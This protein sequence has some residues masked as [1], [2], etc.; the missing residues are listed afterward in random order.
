LKK[1][2]LHMLGLLCFGTMALGKSVTDPRSLEEAF[3]EQDT[4]FLDR[5]YRYYLRARVTDSGLVQVTLGQVQSLIESPAAI[6]TPWLA[7]TIEWMSGLNPPPEQWITQL[8]KLVVSPS[9]KGPALEAASAQLVRLSPATSLE[10]LSERLF[11]YSTKEEAPTLVQALAR[12]AQTETSLARTIVSR[13][14]LASEDGIAPEA[15]IKALGEL[16]SLEASATDS[17]EALQQ[18]ARK[19]SEPGPTLACPF[20]F[21]VVSALDGEP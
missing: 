11:S 8:E 4:V 17:R 21:K 15:V 12:L 7:P 5:A 18:A 3:Q 6:S 19:R 14:H 2:A 1:L 16:E 20:V 9:C 10:P 13:L